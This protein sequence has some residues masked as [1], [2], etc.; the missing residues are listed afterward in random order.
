MRNHEP[1]FNDP[2]FDSKILTN[3]VREFGKSG[4]LLWRLFTS[5]E[6]P[7]WTK[8]VPILALL[9]WLSPFDILLIPFIG[10]T[11]LDDLAVILLGAKLF[12]ELSPADLVERLRDEIAYG[13]PADD[14]GEIIDTTYHVVDDDQ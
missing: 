10:V 4:S 3:F 12:V 13:R 1:P 7:F 9:Y 5:A 11:P 14:R 6:V 8:L 2:G